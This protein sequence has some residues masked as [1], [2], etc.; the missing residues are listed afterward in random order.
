MS[1]K[2]GFMTK[3]IPFIRE[4][5]GRYRSRAYW[6]FAKL[7][8]IYVIERFGTQ[9]SLSVDAAYPKQFLF[10]TKRDAVKA[11]TEYEEAH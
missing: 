7:D 5:A 4:G 3:E 8:H 1:D 10:A 6:G 9:W 11:A 2:P